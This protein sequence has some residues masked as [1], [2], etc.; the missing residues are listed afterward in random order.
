MSAPRW[1]WMP[2]DTSGVKRCRS[3][4]RGLRKVTPSSSTIALRSASAAMTSASVSWETSMARVFL[5]PA[6]RLS[7][8]K[9][10]ESVK[11]GPVQFMNRPRPPA[12]SINS[13]PGCR[14]RW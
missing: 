4:L 2:I 14:K 8:W 9:P 10:P 6:P 7:T 1:C 13:G 11:V 12:S 3:P 5:K